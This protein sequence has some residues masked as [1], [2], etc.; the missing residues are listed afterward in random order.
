MPVSLSAASS[1][2]SASSPCSTMSPGWK[3]TRF[4]TA[5]HSGFRRPRNSRFIAKCLN[6]SPCAF[7][8]IARASGSR[9]TSSRCSYQPIASAS[10]INEAQIR[11][12]VRTS[13]ES[14]SGGSWYW[15]N[16]TIGTLVGMS[17]TATTL[18]GE[19]V[20]LEPMTAAH[21]DGL[22]EASRDPE[23]WRWLSVFQ[24]ETR[25]EMHDYVE[26]ALA[27]A[28]GRNGDAVHDDPAGGRPRAREH[29]LSRAPA[30]A[31]QPRDRLDVADSRGLGNGRQHRGQAADARATPSSGSAACASS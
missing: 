6:S 18:E 8:M 1:S 26:S 13:G 9:S 16:G 12:N 24:P 27:T 29:A 25:E 28:G 15:S 4:R 5:A 11:A 31:P 19:L 14:S 17:W 2:S 7:S 21:E 30:G 20:R 10:S 3:R 22:W 23:T